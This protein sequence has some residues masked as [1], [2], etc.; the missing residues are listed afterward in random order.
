M[1][2]DGFVTEFYIAVKLQVVAPFKSCVEDPWWPGE[3][4]RHES[5]WVSV[6][7]TV[8]KQMLNHFFQNACA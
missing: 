5:S 7:A 8:N 1:V 4:H 6:T 2:L 3:S